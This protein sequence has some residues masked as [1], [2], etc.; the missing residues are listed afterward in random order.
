MSVRVRSPYRRI[1]VNVV[2]PN[3]VQ[4]VKVEAQVPK[5]KKKSEE[6]T[7]SSDSDEAL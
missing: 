5:R 1:D 4:Q 2:V 7:E 6:I 3:Q